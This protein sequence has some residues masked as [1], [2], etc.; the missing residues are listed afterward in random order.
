MD[1]N[2]IEP[3]R[4]T[5]EKELNLWK[6]AII[7]FDSS[8]L[9][10][11]YFS[12][13]SEREKID[14]EIFSELENRL[15]LPNHVQYE[16]LKNRENIIKK[17]ITEK[18]DPL[19]K[20]IENLSI[21]SKLEVSKRID[22]II[23]ETINGDKHPHLKQD[24]LDDF[25]IVCDDFVKQMD[26][27]KKQ[28]DDFKKNILNEISLVEKE[29]TDVENDDDVLNS[30]ETHF[31]VGREFTFEEIIEITKEGK[32]RYEFKIP[33][34]YGDY[35][36]GE[37]K[38]TQVFGDLIIWKQILEYSKEEKKPI[39]FITNDITKDDDWCYIDK[40]A[41]E[42]R[43][44]SPREE[45]IKEIK[46]A[47]SV[48]FWMYNLP[49]FLYHANKYLKSTIKDETIQNFFQFINTK[50]NKSNYLKF[51]CNSCGRIHKYDESEFNLDFDCVG[52]SERKMGIE[53]QYQAEEHFKCSCG[54]EIEVKFEVWEYPQ[55][56]HNYDSI[57]IENGELLD[58]FYFTIDFYEDEDYDFITCHICDGNKEGMGNFV[59]FDGDINLDNEFVDKV[60]E[61]EYLSVSSGS[62][63]W[64]SSLHIECPNCGA[65]TV[66]DQNSA[67]ENIECEGG[68][69]LIF[70]MDT[71]DDRENFGD[72]NL[73]LV[74]VRIKECADCGEK[75]VDKSLT[76]IC[77]DCEEKYDQ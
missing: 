1:R 36:S 11:L 77:D 42:Q 52:G 71:T 2:A 45:L 31:K 9:L 73:K 30:L 3:Y 49:Q 41:N 69:G 68:C 14:K 66:M 5:E 74:D 51:K 70:K 18:Y 33:P 34:G 40:K 15:W 17:P 64:C 26:D 29:I 4:L 57:E 48:D 8:S 38:G 39:I 53:Y 65:V 16:Y 20:K 43:I 75:F 6:D 12:P 76:G 22:E 58:S 72:F 27:F 61:K 55:G 50:K 13:K 24:L 25:K 35:H 54:N 67:N 63:D 44:H 59:R 21:G 60:P 32:H 23:R 10:D 37:K 56:I 46:D 19:K 62:C 7:I 28:T 47:S